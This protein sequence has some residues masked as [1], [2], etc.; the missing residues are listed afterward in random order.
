MDLPTEAEA[1]STR[2]EPGSGPDDPPVDPFAGDPPLARIVRKADTAVGLAEQVVLVGLG[3]FV[4]VVALLWLV[5]EHTSKTPLENA[6]ADIRY[7][8]FLMA[9]IGGA[10]AAHHR[11]LLSMDVVNRMIS[12]RPRAY[13][14]LVT[15]VFALVV[16]AAFFWYS[17]EIYVAT[18][19]EKAI[20]HWMPAAAA[21]AAM[22]I[23]AALLLFHLTAQL[24]IDLAYL[25]AG[26]TPPEP[27]M[28]AA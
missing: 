13:L 20:E 17:K 24:V 6:S 21:K 19:D 18:A 12:G 9:M 8:V 26:K 3:V 16:T 1:P 4:I 15:L 22:M 5:T 2:A 7:T 25:A 14:R 11:R 10:Y 27:E 23:G 28:G